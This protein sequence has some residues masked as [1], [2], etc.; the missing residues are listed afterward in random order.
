MALRFNG[1]KYG[2]KRVEIDG[3]K[4]SSRM[5]GERYKILRD[6]VGNT[7]CEL[8]LQPRFI[9][10]DKFRYRDEN[11]R[12]I[13]YVADFRYTMGL[14]RPGET[15][16]KVC[17]DVKGF[18]LPEF[19]LKLKIWKKLYGHLYEFRIVKGA[20]AVRTPPI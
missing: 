17:E 4:F 10:Q 18:I 5:E 13:E 20:K 6:A 15:C 8:E 11:I 14:G 9:L 19:K 12:A 16:Y 2:A 3:H 7:I 1:S